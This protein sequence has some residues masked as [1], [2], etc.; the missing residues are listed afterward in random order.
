MIKI[1]PGRKSRYLWCSHNIPILS[2]RCTKTY[3]HWMNN[4]RPWCISRQLWWGHR[5]PAWYC[6]RDGS[7]HVSRADLTACPTCKGPVRQDPDVLDTWFSSGL[8][9]FSTLGWPDKTPELKMFY[10]TSLLV[11]GYDIL[12]FWV[13]RMAMFCVHVMRQVPFRD[14]YIHTLVRHPEG[15]KMSKTRGNVV[16]P[17]VLMDRYGTDALRFTLAGRSEEHTSELQSPFL[18]SYA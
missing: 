9:P 13:A 16:D 12:F 7:I 2:G 4:I 6:E 10:P 1:L 5:I 15:Q 14:V 8:W 18:I 17:L 3:Y 11:T